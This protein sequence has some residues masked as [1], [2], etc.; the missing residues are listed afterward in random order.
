MGTTTIKPEM[1]RTCAAAR[2]QLCQANP[3]GRCLWTMY[4]QEKLWLVTVDADAHAEWRRSRVVDP[5][6]RDLQPE[7]DMSS[8]QVSSQSHPAVSVGGLPTRHGSGTSAPPVSG[9]SHLRRPSDT[10]L[11][12]AGFSVTGPRLWNNL[13]VELRQRDIMPERV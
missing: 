3:V 9:C 5:H 6:Q 4:D 11:A 10:D 12:I 2:W 8:V 1:V 7:G 13:P